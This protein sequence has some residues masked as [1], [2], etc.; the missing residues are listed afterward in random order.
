MDAPEQERTQN[1]GVSKQAP[2]LSHSRVSR[3]LHCPEQYRLYYHENLRRRVPD[4]SLVFGK[5]VH[6]ALEALF[7]GGED[8]VVTFRT[9]WNA[10]RQAPVRYKDRESWDKLL[11][12]GVTLMEQFARTDV[13]RITTVRAVERPFTVTVTSLSL[14][15]VGIIDLVADV[16]G[17]RTVLDFKTSATTYPP[18][19]AALSDQLTAY[20]L[21]E[22]DATQTALCVL[23]K[24]TQPKIEW[25][26]SR[27]EPADLTRYIAKAGYVAQ[28][29]TAERF[30]RR[31]GRWCSYCDY[32]PV[33]LGDEALAERTLV[34]VLAP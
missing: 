19:E 7:R 25:H 10:I 1:G 14:K 31:P 21:A 15:L 9:Q 3:Y 2:H 24:T 23:V 33:C 20:Q 26:L 22:P 29:I 18:F 16:D 11:A 32:L 30:Y 34:K 4:A 5:I 28:E 13:G 6:A 12:I 27:R 17:Q 8:P